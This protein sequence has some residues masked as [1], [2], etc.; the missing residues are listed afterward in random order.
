M[1]V[2]CPGT[3]TWAQK[4]SS[5]FPSWLSCSGHRVWLCQ[6]GSCLK[7]DGGWAGALAWGQAAA[8]CPWEQTLLLGRVQNHGLGTA[9]VARTELHLTFTDI[10]LVHIYRPLFLPSFGDTPPNHPLPHPHAASLLS[11]GETGAEKAEEELPRV[12]ERA[13]W[14]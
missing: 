12:I 5:P 6:D 2:G 1:L 11:G 3:G 4:V 10:V 9:G 7:E 8:Q 14:S 13:D